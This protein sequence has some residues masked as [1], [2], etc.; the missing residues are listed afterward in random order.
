MSLRSQQAGR[1]AESFDNDRK[2]GVY[3]PSGARAHWFPRSVESLTPDAQAALDKAMAQ[4]DRALSPET[5][6]KYLANQAG[7]LGRAA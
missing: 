6:A 1:D 2:D 3:S 4:I 5:R 7:K